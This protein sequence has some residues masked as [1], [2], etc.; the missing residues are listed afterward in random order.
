M[1]L[2]VRQRKNRQRRLLTNMGWTRDCPSQA[3]KLVRGIG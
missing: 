2:K 1:R 3:G